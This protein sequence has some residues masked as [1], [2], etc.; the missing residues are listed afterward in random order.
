ELGPVRVELQLVQP[1]I[2]E[3]RELP[4]GEQEPVG[5]GIDDN[6]A[7]AVEVG[8]DLGRLLAVESELEREGLL[9]DVEVVEQFGAHGAEVPL[10]EWL[11]C[12]D[13]VVE[14]A[15][16]E[17]PGRLEQIANLVGNFG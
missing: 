12:L 11:E 2:A 4:V 5:H 16:V 14:L 13:V 9:V 15:C 7:R 8:Y 6:L 3:A 17:A 1:H 10:V